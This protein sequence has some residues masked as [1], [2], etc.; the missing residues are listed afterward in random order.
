MSLGLKSNK[1]AGWGAEK[2][3]PCMRMFV[4]MQFWVQ[5]NVLVLKQLQVQMQVQ[6]QVHVLPISPL[7]QVGE[8]LP[9]GMHV[10]HDDHLVVGITGIIVVPPL[11]HGI[12]YVCRGVGP[13]VAYNCHYLLQ[14]ML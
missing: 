11:I 4:R 10:I 9:A 1:G 7:L 3:P 5:L 12:L 13:A 6:V 8:L 14:S 2:N